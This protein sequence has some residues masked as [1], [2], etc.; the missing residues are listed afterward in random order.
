DQFQFAMPK[1]WNGLRIEIIQRQTRST[2]ISL[3]FPIAVTRR[4]A[5]WPALE[6]VTSYFG[7]HRSSNSHLYQCLRETRGLNYGD[8]AYIEYFP[9][10]MFQFEPDPNLGRHYQTFQIWIRPVEPQ[11]GLFAL[12]AAL[13]EYNKLWQN[14]LS[15]AAFDSTREFLGKYANLLTQT[16]SARLGYALDSRYYGI[17]D[18]PEFLRTRMSG[19]TVDEVNQAIRRDFSPGQMQA[20]IVTQEAA[21]LRQAILE[22]KPS[23]I[24]YNAPKPKEILDE[25]RLIEHYPLEVKPAA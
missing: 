4:D 23:S 24:T 12:R 25:D 3:G 1:P 18:F 20:V 22:Q 17:G 21:A 19:L 6:V 14:G 10:G 8:Y 16:Q 7:Q 15:P 5:D 13:Y 2:A 9:S 11:N